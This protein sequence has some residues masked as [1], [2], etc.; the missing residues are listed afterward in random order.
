MHLVNELIRG[1]LTDRLF[2]RL[3]PR[4]KRRPGSA[5]AGGISAVLLAGIAIAA[6]LGVVLYQTVSSRAEDTPPLVIHRPKTFICTP[7]AWHGAQHHTIPPGQK[8]KDICG[9]SARADLFYDPVP[10]VN[11]IP[12]PHGLHTTHPQKSQPDT[13]SKTP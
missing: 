7:P 11:K 9:T 8:I 6:A 12:P 10:H 2:L 3:I 13:G 5:Q 4:T 1:A